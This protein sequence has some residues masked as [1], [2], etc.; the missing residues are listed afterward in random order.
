MSFSSA[1]LSHLRL[2][3]PQQLSNQ[4]SCR[5]GSRVLG[6]EDKDEKAPLLSNLSYVSHRMR[7]SSF[8]PKPSNARGQIHRELQFLQNT[9]G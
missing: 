8:R 3:P 4:A 9:S 7:L 2:R 1:D 5:G 6:A